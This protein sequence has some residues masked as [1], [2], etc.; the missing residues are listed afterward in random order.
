VEYD[1]RSVVSTRV[2]F[3]QRARGRDRA[4]RFRGSRYVGMVSLAYLSR[5]RSCSFHSR[6]WYKLD[7][8]RVSVILTYPT[9]LIPFCTWLL[10]GYFK[11]IPTSSR[12]R[13]HRRC[14]PT[15]NPRTHH[16]AARGAGLISAGIFA[17]TLS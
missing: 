17:F 10:M 5:R 13:A 15:A 4:T 8:T 12:M 3:L 16:L 14:Q 11:S 2:G 6:R 7:L 9:F 1:R